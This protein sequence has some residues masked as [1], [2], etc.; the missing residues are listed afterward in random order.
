VA[1]LSFVQLEFTYAVGPPPG[2]YVV[3][4][5]DGEHDEEA[6]ERP[7]PYIDITGITRAAGSADVLVIGTFSAPPARFFRRH[8][9]VAP[10]EEEPVPLS[11]A[12]LIH[13]TKPLSE[14]E[15][16]TLLEGWR[17]QRERQA[18]L[19]D[20]ALAV[21][22]T[23]ICAYR[24]AASD[25]YVTE[26][27][28]EDARAIRLGYGAAEEV[29]RGEWQAAIPA[30]APKGRRRRRASSP[31]VL[32]PATAV[33]AALSGAARISEGEQVLLRAQLDLAQ[34]R[35]RAAALELRSAAELLA[36]ELAGAL[37]PGEDDELIEHAMRCREH[38][39]ALATQA[40]S[41]SPPPDEQDLDAL[42]ADVERLV[43]ARAVRLA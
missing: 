33:G 41:A 15:A 29:Y 24:A 16:A 22:N 26:L 2:R 6:E 36:A 1:L 23:G 3:T 4:P 37:E 11:L 13:A 42:L 38:A 40:L 28:R 12:T 34:G 43:S 5:L 27:T 20:R 14:R 10:D 30:A 17:E 8:T 32:A 9:K 19:V 39:G 18:P 21:L 7:A 25:P 35:A 31:E